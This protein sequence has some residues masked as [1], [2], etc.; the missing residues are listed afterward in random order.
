M[1]PTKPLVIAPSVFTDVAV[2]TVLRDMSEV[3][4][5]ESSDGDDTSLNTVTNH[6]D[7]KISW[8]FRMA[9]IFT[10]TY[11]THEDMT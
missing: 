7:E 2:S 9:V 3:E 11:K 10:V 5:A 4:E 6:K 1:D 8:M